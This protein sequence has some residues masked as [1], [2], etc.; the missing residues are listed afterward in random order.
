VVKEGENMKAKSLILIL[1]LL[2]STVPL[3]MRVNATEPVMWISGTGMGHVGGEYT[4]QIVVNSTTGINVNAWEFKITWNKEVLRYKSVT[5]LWH[6]EMGLQDYYI[7]AIGNE[8]WVFNG[9]LSSTQ[10][11]ALSGSVPIASVTWDI[12]AG[13]ES[14]INFTDGSLW[15]AIIKPSLE[16]ASFM[17]YE[18]FVDFDWTPAAPRAGETVT[19][20]ASKCYSPE[21]QE[22]LSYQWYIDGVLSGTGVTTTASFATYSKTAHN[23]TLVVT[24]TNH[25]SSTLEKDLLIDRD[26]AIFSIWPS[27]EDY[28]GSIPKEIPAG[29]TV[30]I[31]VRT[32]NVGTITEYTNNSKG[33]FPATTK[34]S[35][36]LVYPDGTEELIGS[37][38]GV[39]LR[40]K[41]VGTDLWTWHYEYDWAPI[42]GVYNWYFWYTSG[43]PPGEY[44]LKANLTGLQGETD[45]DNNVLESA[46]FKIV[47]GFE[48]DI[49]LDGVWT[50]D[51][52]GYF[53]PSPPFPPDGD[54]LT[55]KFFYGPYNPIAENIYYDTDNSANVTA[56]D[57]RM[58][59]TSGTTTVVA[60]D[61]SDIGL[62]LSDDGAIMFN[63]TDGS[64]TW[65]FGEQVYYDY[66]GSG[67]V[68]EGDYRIPQHTIVEAGDPDENLTLSYDSLLRF[69]E[70]VVQGS[71]GPGIAG[72]VW[73]HARPKAYITVALYNI[74]KYIADID[75]DGTVGPVDLGKMGAAWGSFGD[76]WTWIGDP[77]YNVLCDLDLDGGVGPTDLGT[78]GAEWGRFGPDETTTLHLYAG[79][80]EIGNMTVTLA[81][82][83]WNEFTIEWDL[84]GFYGIYTVQAYVEPVVG[85]TDK[86]AQ[87]DN[88]MPGQAIMFFNAYDDWG[89]FNTYP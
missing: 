68:S 23:I 56:G 33:D 28:M 88:N 8:L 52:V 24:D 80:V 61:D 67:D 29:K 48:H 58:N 34:L 44:Y 78:M 53:H 54:G 30:V 71:L 59:C 39:R 41:R 76:P 32:C 66:D 17:T 47:P 3:A 82:G 75:A 15:D 9:F 13:G 64:G 22:P 46:K 87:W 81:F 55:F 79:G 36:Y 6:P 20:N 83:E 7:G 1:A 5:W 14:Y 38:A 40:R 2:L 73:D 86:W 12:V 85:E 18:P 69:Y 51:D 31:M 45:L 63:D 65:E 11:S 57:Y 74:G 70:A 25:D 77:N 35:L 72:P 19:F 42:V 50:Y 49:T 37:T 16:N 21:H 89:I 62:P 43:Y 26:L 84:S 4:V 10:K 60:A 27:I